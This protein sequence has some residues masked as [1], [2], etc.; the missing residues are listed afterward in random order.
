MIRSSR[1]STESLAACQASPRFSSVALVT[2]AMIRNRK[3]HQAPVVDDKSVSFRLLDEVGRGGMGVVYRAEQIY[4]KR[5]VALKIMKAELADVYAHRR[6]EREIEL[7][8]RLNHP[9]I[10]QL[11]SAGLL[12]GA[13]GAKTPFLAMEFVFGQPL[14][15]YAQQQHLPLEQRMRLFVKVCDTLVYAH[16]QG[17]IHRDLKPSNILVNDQGEPKIL[18]FGLAAGLGEADNS[19]S[20]LTMP[21]QMVGTLEYMSPEQAEGNTLHVDQQADVYALGVVLYELLTAQR[22]FCFK[23]RNIVDAVQAIKSHTPPPISAVSRTLRGDL[24]TIV[25]KAMA[26][27]K[28]QRYASVSALAEDV[29]RYLANEPIRARRPSMSY[30]AGRFVRRNRLFVTAVAAIIVALSTGLIVA[31]DQA[32]KARASETRAIEQARRADALAQV[33]DREAALAKKAAREAEEALIRMRIFIADNVLHGGDPNRALRLYNEAVGQQPG[34]PQKVRALDLKTNN[35]Q[36]IQEWD[37]HPGAIETL[38]ISPDNHIAVVGYA[39][40]RVVMSDLA[41]KERPIETKFAMGLQGASFSPNGQ[42]VA[43][44]AGAEFQ[45]WSLMKAVKI[46]EGAFSGQ[47]LNFV[48]LSDDTVFGATD[49][50]ELNAISLAATGANPPALSVPQGIKSVAYTPAGLLIIDGNYHV[51]RADVAHNTLQDRAIIPV[52]GTA[53]VALA[54]DGKHAAAWAVNRVLLFDIVKGTVA[55]QFEGFNDPERLGF[56]DSESIYVS[57]LEELIIDRYDMSGKLLH[58]IPTTKSAK[59]ALSRNFALV[60]IPNGALLLWSMLPN[61][62]ERTPLP[63]RAG[64]SDT[65]SSPGGSGAP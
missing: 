26:K 21:G 7:L 11:Y 44:H 37:S 64:L 45:V 65:L 15:T 6:F 40:G 48:A 30:V 35:V 14:V 1:S 20:Q 53:K 27:E 24:D 29:R 60:A 57:S 17:V 23:D 31:A 19:V 46:K 56:V 38:A 36:L 63:A 52:S 9:G 32:L 16:G 4:P 13:T 22:P 8:A 34:G 62:D 10:A 28:S 33:A 47:H 61:P 50:Q 54:P 25:Q 5:I 59:A 58:S 12:D 51:L 39:D 49:R 3:L 2:G 42:Y 18:D 41:K 43:L 55:A